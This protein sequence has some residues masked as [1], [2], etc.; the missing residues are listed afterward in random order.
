[1]N[2]EPVNTGDPPVS[3]VYQLIVAPTL[4]V[5]AAKLT[6]PVPQRVADVVESIKLVKPTLTGDEATAVPPH[7]AT[8][9]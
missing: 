9:H 6:E 8:K 1:M 7:T 5:V 3:A 4:E 2:G